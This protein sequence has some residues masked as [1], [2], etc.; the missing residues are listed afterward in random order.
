[1][2]L[3][4]YAFLIFIPLLGFMLVGQSPAT[5]K[6]KVN[7]STIA[8]TLA[9]SYDN[10]KFTGPSGWTLVGAP[11]GTVE[12]VIDNSEGKRVFTGKYKCEKD[13]S[14]DMPACILSME[15]GK[16]APYGAG[17]G[18]HVLKILMAG[19]EVY[20]FEF[21]LSVSNEGETKNVYAYGD[22]SNVGKLQIN[23]DGSLAATLFS[24]SPESCKDTAPKD[25]QV[26]IFRNGRFFARGHLEGQY[27]ESCSTAE[28]SMTLFREDD[29]NFTYWLKSKDILG[30]DG[31]YVVS[32][33]EDRLL[34]RSY[35]FTVSDGKFTS[36]PPLELH[37]QQAL[38]PQDL[39]VEEDG[40][41]WFYAK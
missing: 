19:K 7:V 6:V 24:G 21:F 32:F 28:L 9:F 5:A 16:A 4:R 35:S 10:G 17:S 15:N 12:I 8:A 14:Y 27:L 1:M 39:N 40:Q 26:Q 11:A 20:S 29:L 37:L 31:A 13:D 2:Y 38:L 41:W 33:F 22:W 25:A 23:E 3:K 36:A 18:K 30:A 34:V